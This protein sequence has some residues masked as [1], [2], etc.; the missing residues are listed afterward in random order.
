MVPGPSCPSCRRS[1][2]QVAGRALGGRAGRVAGDLA[3]YIHPAILAQ[4]GTRGPPSRSLPGRSAVPV[5]L[6]V[7]GRERGLPEAGLEVAAYYIVS[8]KR[9]RIPRSTR[10]P[11]RLYV[12]R[13]NRPTE[14][15]ALSIRD[16]GPRRGRS[17]PV[18]PDSSASPTALTRSAGTIEVASPR[19]SGND[20]ADQGF[21]SKRADRA[22]TFCAV[23]TSRKLRPCT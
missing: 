21:P 18:V 1:W 9:S 2:S 16:D 11:P 4:G 20:A 10:T 3:R 5:E 23:T 22:F 6:E 8:E 14:V 13:S 17:G 19:R 12:P 7:R 15:L